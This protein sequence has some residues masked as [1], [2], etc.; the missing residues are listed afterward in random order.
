M[1]IALDTG[2][3]DMRAEIQTEKDRR[4]REHRAKIEQRA[5]MA[6]TLAAGVKP[7]LNLLGQGDSWFD[8]PLPIPFPSDVLT[9]LKNL[10]SMSPEVLSLAHYGEA[11]EAMLGVRKLHEFI[12][13]LRHPANGNWDGIL[14]SGGGN[15]LAGD[16]FR[17]WLAEAESR[18]NNS[19]NGLNQDR[20]N[21]I[22]GVVAAAYQDLFA[23]RDSFDRSIPIFGHSYDFAIPSGIGV[24]CAGP[25]LKPSLEDRGWTAPSAARAIV[26]N[27]LIQFDAMLQTFAGVPANNFILV[28]TQGTLP[29]AEWANELHPN[30]DGFA[31]ITVKFV[32]AL[33]TR[34][35]GRI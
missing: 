12:D 8:Y 25:W 2:Y 35:P 29:D 9:H 23:A 19:E 30:P 24:A 21:S 14:F 32:E 17:L 34:F 11:A 22:L 16:Q 33:R 5:R 26:K 15:D 7:A 18:G 3:R 28:K 20:V 4:I 1:A 31:A 10:P 6:V 13:Q 27:L